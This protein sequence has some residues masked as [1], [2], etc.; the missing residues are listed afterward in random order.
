MCAAA[1]KGM[2][3]RRG[4]TFHVHVHDHVFGSMYVLWCL[5]LF[6]KILSYLHSNKKCLAIF[7]Q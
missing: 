5:V 2:G 3:G 1:C 4:V 6:V 7:L